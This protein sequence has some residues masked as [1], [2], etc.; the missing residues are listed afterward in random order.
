MNA[1]HAMT[2]KTERA[3]LRHMLDLG[4]WYGA[5]HVM[6]DDARAAVIDGLEGLCPAP[7]AKPGPVLRRPRNFRPSLLAGP[8]P[9]PQIIPLPAPVQGPP[10]NRL[11]AI[12]HRVAHKYRMDPDVLIGDRRTRDVVAARKEFFIAASNETM[13]SIVAIAR[14]ANRDHSTVLHHLRDER[15]KARA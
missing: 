10:V 12:L 11:M 3:A 7:K 14:F 4:V 5:G 2:V 15:E 6:P 9:K 8:K 1:E 13:A